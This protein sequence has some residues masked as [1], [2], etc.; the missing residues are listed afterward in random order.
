MAGGQVTD[1]QLFPFTG[2]AGPLAITPK[3][4]V[5]TCFTIKGNVVD[6][7]K[8]NPWDANQSF[9]F[10]SAAAAPAPAPAAPATQPA[11]VPACSVSATTTAITQ[12]APPKATSTST[13]TS[14][15]TTVSSP[16]SS[17]KTSSSTASS[18]TTTPAPN[19]I[20]ATNPTTPVPVSRAGGVLQPSAAAESHQ[21][22]ATATRAFTKVS[23]KA[24]N[25]QCL[26]ID[27]TAG[28]F[29]ENLIP[30][31]MKDC[32]GSLNEKFDF[33]TAGKHNNAK[34]AT[35][36]VSSLVSLHLFYLHSLAYGF[37]D[38]RVRQLRRSSRRR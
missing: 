1:S 3:N 23:L 12:V 21:F 18:A 30:I 15:S 13:S 6:Q 9:T 7:A 37:L 33:I 34:G 19:N 27:P 36:I 14:T 20:P 25:G 2:G 24:A 26:F 22:D 29:R 17:T 35:L 10:G 16:A 28:D 4:A 32:D 38:E 31:S 8:C 11:A 5:G